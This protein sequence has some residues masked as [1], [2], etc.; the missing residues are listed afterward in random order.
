LARIG[1]TQ[2][3]TVYDD[4]GLVWERKRTTAL[5]EKSLFKYTAISQLEQVTDC[6]LEVTT[7]TCTYDPLNRLET[8]SIDWLGQSMRYQYDDASRLDFIE[9]FNDME[10]DYH[11]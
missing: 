4:R 6:N 8:V 2:V 1:K 5:G 7:F 10:T 3:P 11:W 9:H